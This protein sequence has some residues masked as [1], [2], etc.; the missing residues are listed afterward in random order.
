MNLLRT[1]LVVSSLL[2]VAACSSTG[3]TTNSKAMNAKCP[4]SGAAIEADSPTT[5]FDGKTI[6]FCCGKCAAKFESMPAAD[7]QAKVTG[8]MPSK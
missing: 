5:T 4:V 8:S 7:K 6:A 3:S 1:A 2:V